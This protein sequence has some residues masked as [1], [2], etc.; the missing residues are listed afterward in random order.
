MSLTDLA[1]RKAKAGEK[2]Y[3]L[4]DCGGL[5][6]EVMPSG[7]KYW[8]F[9]SRVGG[10]TRMATIG[11]YP[12]VDLFSARTKCEELRR[13]IAN[14][15]DFR[16]L[17]KAPEGTSFES[18]AR[19][20]YAKNI[21]GIKTPKHQ[22]KVLSRL[23]RFLFPRF[24]KKTIREITPQEILVVL[25]VVEERGQ[26]ETAHTLLGILK[27]IWRYA[28]LSGLADTNPADVLTG[29]LAPVV[30][31]HN[32]TLTDTKKI[33]E[34][35]LSMSA[36]SGSDT[37]KNALLFSAYVFCRPREIRH[38]EWGE[39]DF[40][41][42]LW[43]IP[44]EKMKMRRTHIVPL[45][46][47]A[48]AILTHMRDFTGDG[49]YVFPS[50]R[51]V[52]AGD[53]PMSENT[54]SAVLRRLGFT[55]DEMSAHGF[56]SMASTVLYENGFFADVVERQLAHTVGSNVRQSYDYSQLL[57]QRREMMQWWADWLDGLREKH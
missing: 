5:Y 46:R 54:I 44:A 26:R 50:I 6:L 24:G 43:R 49:K 10:E 56:R 55:K 14:G 9:R 30:V 4:N 31:K 53:V 52:A 32:A 20:W 28:V 51:A 35:V 37:V 39:I 3:S 21:E 17:I 2:R 25:R 8:R 19:E 15:K 11:V 38:A 47:Q 22:Y 18:V 41:E 42:H 34:L 13:E 45:S 23:E 12:E 48:E 16:L 29:A 33:R 27:Q 57:P 7:H 1:A 40:D 36:F